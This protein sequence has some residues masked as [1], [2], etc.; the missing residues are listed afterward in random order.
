MAINHTY[1]LGYYFACR[2]NSIIKISNTSEQIVKFGKPVHSNRIQASVATTITPKE[3]RHLF[4]N[5]TSVTTI[6]QRQRKANIRIS[7]T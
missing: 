3:T 1:F 7:I 4:H 5:R 6:Q 2:N